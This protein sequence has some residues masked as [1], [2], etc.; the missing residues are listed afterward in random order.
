MTVRNQGGA[1]A[2]RAT[3]RWLYSTN[4]AI[5]PDDPV[6]GYDDSVPAPLRSP[7]GETAWTAAITIIDDAEVDAVEAIVLDAT[8][9]N[10]TRTGAASD[11]D[12]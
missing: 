11:T 8:S 1:R 7:K 6:I 2:R 3:I 12:H 9:A 5:T 4:S 10:P